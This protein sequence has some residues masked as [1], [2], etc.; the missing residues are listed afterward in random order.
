MQMLHSQIKNEKPRQTEEEPV[1]KAEAGPAWASERS[2][3][4]DLRFSVS[5]AKW[6]HLALP[7]AL[8]FSKLN[9]S[10]P[11]HGMKTVPFIVVWDTV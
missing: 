8:K 3:I 7:A 4:G 9:G 6:L 1:A 11:G 2:G 5:A 10:Y